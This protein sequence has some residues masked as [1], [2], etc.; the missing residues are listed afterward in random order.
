MTY[1]LGR[2]VEPPDMAVIRRIVKNSS[3]RNYSLQ[4]I[5]SGIVESAP[6]QMRTRLEAEPTTTRG[7]EVVESGFSRIRR[8]RP[9]AGPDDSQ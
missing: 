5:I 8:V 2:G 3:Q 6:F 7:G 4:S 9:L 1:A